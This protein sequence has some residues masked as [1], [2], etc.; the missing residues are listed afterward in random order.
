MRTILTT[1]LLLIF[2]IAKTSLATAENWS[3]PDFKIEIGNVVSLGRTLVLT[4]N[5]GGQILV[6]VPVQHLSLRDNP[7]VSLKFAE[8]PPAQI[9]VIWRTDASQEL[10]QKGFRSFGKS[11]ISFDMTGIKGWNGKASSLEFGFLVQPGQQIGLL[12]AS[13]YRPGISDRINEVLANWLDFKVWRPVDV[14]VY[15]GTSE[16]SVGPYPAQIFAAMSL[17]LVL[18][19]LAMRR[20]KSKLQSVALIVFCS[21][22][23]LDSFWQ[24]RLW[25]Q[26]AETRVQYAG[27]TSED[28]LAASEDAV[29]A[30][31]AAAA[32]QSITRPDARVFIAGM[33]DYQ[34][35]TSAYYLSPFNSYWHRHGPELPDAKYLQSGDYILLL[36]ASDINYQP[37]L[38]TIQLDTGT[39]LKV[40]EHMSDRLGVL[41]EVL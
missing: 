22:L 31:F 11:K 40:Q 12:E 41:L 20:G 28:K 15:T 10:F 39:Q 24:L 29:F 5:P 25:R 26:L 32:R 1:F 21:W 37:A 2:L 6:S 7:R 38:S 14:N 17:A 35:M 34:T 36:R 19:Y 13:V 27:K 30:Q 4:S 33:H 23:A 18:L 9:F 8:S 3:A 16:F